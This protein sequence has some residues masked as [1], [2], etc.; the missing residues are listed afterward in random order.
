MFLFAGTEN[1]VS[2]LYTRE[3]ERVYFRFAKFSGHIGKC[4][5]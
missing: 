5:S 4:M 3:R 2:E 1:D